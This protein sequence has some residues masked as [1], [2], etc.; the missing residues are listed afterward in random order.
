MSASGIIDLYE[1]HAAAWAELR[2]RSAVIESGWLE[3]FHS[4]LPEG[5]T[6][7][8]LGCGSGA[9][10]A[11]WLIAR[12]YGVTGLDASP[13]LIRIS[14]IR[15]PAAEWPAAEWIVSDMRTPDL[16]RSFDGVIAWH[17]LF[18]LSPDDQRR[19]FKV[20]ARLTSPGG[21]VMFTSGH[22]AGETIGEFQG[23]PLYHA[24]LTLAE[25]NDLLDENGFDV[26]DFTRCDP[27][28]G[29][30]TVWLARRRYQPAN[31]N[32]ETP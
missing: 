4:A 21:A 24:S 11:A 15:F 32:S 23:E 26:A 9:P 27:D 5:G 18:H 6:V 3:K 1:R 31:A 2:C 29:A 20:F 19:M 14:R 22:K 28:C 10:I 17:S 30:A 12:G 25:Y 13:S 16:S 7:L 8:D